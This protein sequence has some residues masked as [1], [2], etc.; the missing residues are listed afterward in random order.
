MATFANPED[1][2]AARPMDE[3]QQYNMFLA[4]WLGV[5]PFSRLPH[6]IPTNGLHITPCT[7]GDSLWYQLTLHLTSVATDECIAYRRIHLPVWAFRE[8]CHPDTKVARDLLVQG[9]LPF[10]VHPVHLGGPTLTRNAYD[11]I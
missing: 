2:V 8:N 4:F 5:S 6:F 7:I 1:P 10:H 9:Q 11:R 3:A